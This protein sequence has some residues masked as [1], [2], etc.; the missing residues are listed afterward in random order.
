VSANDNLKTSCGPVSVKTRQIHNVTIGHQGLRY[1]QRIAEIVCL[2]NSRD[3][4]NK[5]RPTI[6]LLTAHWL[7][8][9]EE[10]VYR[11]IGKER[12][13]ERTRRF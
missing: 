9:S 10:Y 12:E 4:G 1:K 3:A 5:T 11:D 8:G 2:N 13:A 7:C 6:L